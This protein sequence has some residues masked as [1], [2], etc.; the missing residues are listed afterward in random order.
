MEADDV[1]VE[2]ELQG[3]LWHRFGK[4]VAGAE[5]EY[6]LK[7]NSITDWGLSYG[8]TVHCL[9]PRITW[10]NKFNTIDLDVKVVGF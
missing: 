1:D 8:R 9:E 10:R 2:T 7:N 6:D 5:I 3:A 4:N